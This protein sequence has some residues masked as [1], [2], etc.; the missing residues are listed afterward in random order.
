MQQIRSRRKKKA[1]IYIGLGMAV[2]ATLLGIGIYALAAPD[3]QES[4]VTPA[5]VNVKNGDIGNATLVV[6]SHLIYI[7]ALT[8]DLYQIAYD[9][10]STFSQPDMYYKSELGGGVWYEVSS[11]TS[12]ADISTAG[13][14]ISNSVIEGLS[15]THYTKADGITYDLLTGQPVNIFDINDPYDLRSMEE[16]RPLATQ[17]QL[18]ESSDTGESGGSG[19][20][21]DASTEDKDK[22]EE[23]RL[24]VKGFFD[25][26]M[27]SD[28][29]VKQWEE[30]LQAVNTYYRQVSSSLNEGDEREV[31]MSVMGKLDA[32][33]RISLYTKLY[34]RLGELGNQIDAGNNSAVTEAV[35]ESQGNLQSSINQY[36]AK[37]FASG[38]TVL[39]QEEYRLMQ[40]LVTGARASDTGACKA[41]L[42]TLGYLYNIKNNTVDKGDAELKYLN[43]TLLP[44][45]KQA[46]KDSLGAGVS[47]ENRQE[48]AGN[49]ILMEQYAEETKSSINAVRTEYQFLISAKIMRMSNE[50]AQA[51]MTTL[52]QGVDE[53]RSAVKQDEAKDKAT[54]TVEQHLVWLR[55]QLT[56]LVNSSRGGS[57]MSILIDEKNQLLQDKQAALDQNQLGEANRIDALIQAKDQDIANLEKEYSDTLMSA[58][59]SEADKAWAAACL[60]NG[61]AGATA[62]AIG[63]ATVSEIQSGNQDNVSKALDSLEALMGSNSGAVTGVLKDIK[64]ALALAGDTESNTDEQL[65]S[66]V[67]SLIE[68]GEDMSSQN[69]L[70]AKEAESYLEELMGGP[71]MSLSAE[72]Q[73]QAVLALEWYGEIKNS[74]AIKELAASYS[75]VMLRNGSRYVYAKLAGTVE[76]YASTKTISEALGYRYVYDDSRMVVTLQK[77]KDYYEFT[78]GK[79]GIRSNTDAAATMNRKAEYQTYIYIPGDFTTQNFDCQIEY[80]DNGSVG[81]LY[82]QSQKELADEIYQALLTKGGD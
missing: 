81:I 53:F 59:A 4:S 57:D 28:P 16:L 34:D 23:L 64:N 12:I 38:T 78:A 56:D 54:E 32:E 11:A 7:G 66:R 74:H 27:R 43:E 80:M 19:E 8:D 17:Y 30:Q 68:T 13:T 48:A 14:P 50:A 46:Y 58:T 49:S 82:T 71:F 5:S 24:K 29:D 67:N 9:S 22:T 36:T 76:E 77:G 1:P 61:T 33:R 15:F 2:L 42:T 47:Q 21:E 41:T 73:Q 39:G 60:S 65:R 70:T 35:I 79:T 63:E 69:G 75:D 72:Q 31:L 52:I 40:E 10:A 51:Y 18:L 20:G 37:G 62:I 55:Q 3:E 25:T 6:G 44:K 26:D 45:G